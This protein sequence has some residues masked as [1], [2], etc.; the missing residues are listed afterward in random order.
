MSGGRIWQR[1]CSTLGSCSGVVNV[2]PRPFGHIWTKTRVASKWR[3]GTFQYR[4][5]CCRITVGERSTS[6]FPG[7]CL[8][9]QSYGYI[10]MGQPKIAGVFFWGDFVSLRLQAA[11]A[12]AVKSGGSL[13]CA[14]GI[15]GSRAF[16]TPHIAI[17][18]A[19]CAMKCVSL[20]TSCTTS[21]ALLV[22]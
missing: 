10:W 13:L 19:C 9:M 20:W 17:L 12:H 7:A 21:A 4:G 11:T 14:G 2:S 3:L 5:I 6:L 16:L 22:P 8:A 15:T 18:W 1:E